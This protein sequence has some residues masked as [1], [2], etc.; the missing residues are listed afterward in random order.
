M[1]RF[2]I[3]LGL[4]LGV[5][6]NAAGEDSG[7]GI[8]LGFSS[9]FG[10]LSAGLFG[11]SSEQSGSG[12]GTSLETSDITTTEAI[13]VDEAGILKMINDILQGTGGLADIFG[14]EAGAGVFDSSA[15]KGGTEDLLA[16]IAGEIAKVTATKT[17]TQAGTKEAE[18]ESTTK[19]SA[20]SPGLIS[21]LSFGLF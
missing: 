12:S 13:E 11:T 21:K 7:F 5:S 2:G 8:D 19:S 10:D 1:K 16:K 4:T 17:R 15:A 3:G 9:T 20:E 6:L 18:Q 14:A